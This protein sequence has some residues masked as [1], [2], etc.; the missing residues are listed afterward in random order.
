MK[1]W[2]SRHSFWRHHEHKGILLSSIVAESL[3]LS[4]RNT[5]AA[6]KCSALVWHTPHIVWHISVTYCWVLVRRIADYWSCWMFE[7]EKQVGDKYSQYVLLR[8]TSV[9][10]ADTSPHRPVQSSARAPFEASDPLVHHLGGDCHLHLST[11]EIPKALCAWVCRCP[12]VSGTSCVTV[13]KTS[14]RQLST[15][16]IALSSESSCVYTNRH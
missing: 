13:T 15:S 14:W 8:G 6:T 2:I 4:V 16:K 9:V 10:H 1:T 7:F 11:H 5:A 12:S 3:G